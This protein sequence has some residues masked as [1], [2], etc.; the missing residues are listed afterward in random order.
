MGSP[1]QITLSSIRSRSSRSAHTSGLHVG[2]L[3]IE[4]MTSFL[5]TNAMVLFGL[6]LLEAAG[7]SATSRKGRQP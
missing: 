1:V 7:I 3:P 5:L 4:E 6:V 2:G